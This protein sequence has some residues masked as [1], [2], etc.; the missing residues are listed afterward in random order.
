MSAIAS[1]A[2]RSR[3][4]LGGLAE[5]GMLQAFVDLLGDVGDLL[6]FSFRLHAASDVRTTASAAR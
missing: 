2:P 5:T 6:A 1:A 3:A 4:L